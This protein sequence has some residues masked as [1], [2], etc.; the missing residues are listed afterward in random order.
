[1]VNT[2]VFK[3]TVEG[4]LKGI[5]RAKLDILI[6]QRQN[7]TMCQENNTKIEGLKDIIESVEKELELNLMQSGEKKI[8]TS[9]GYVSYRTMPDKWEYTEKILWSFI[10]SL[11]ETLKTLFTKVTVTIKK[12]YLNKRIINDNPR[13]FVEG[14][15]INYEPG[16]QLYLS[17]KK[18]KGIEIKRQEP[19]FNYKIK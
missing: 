11:P 15:L 14:K 6:L 13:E 1:M 5:A 9:A 2:D 7:E 12:G 18:V 8:D 17:D 16:L 19:K 10:I 4:D 3:T